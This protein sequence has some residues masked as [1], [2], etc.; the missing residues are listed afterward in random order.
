MALL[1]PSTLLRPLDFPK[2]C[3]IHAFVTFTQSKSLESPCLYKVQA[4]SQGIPWQRRLF[5]RL[6]ASKA[7]AV[8]SNFP[9]R[10]F[11]VL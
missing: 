5:V 3:D 1:A 11:H 7:L 4:L 10:A 2:S 8:Y 9:L 6:D